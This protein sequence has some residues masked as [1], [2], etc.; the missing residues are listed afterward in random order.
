MSQ[1]LFLVF[2]IPVALALV[3]LVVI[4]VGV[5]RVLASLCRPVQLRAPPDDDE[6]KDGYQRVPA[7]PLE[8]E[9]RTR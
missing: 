2:P 1:N 7:D 6:H 9:L 8:H 4:L 5:A 3:A